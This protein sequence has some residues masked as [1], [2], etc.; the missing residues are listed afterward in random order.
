[1]ISMHPILYYGKP[2]HTWQT[3][4]PKG[5]FQ[6]GRLTRGLS[7]DNGHPCPKPI[8]DWNWLMQKISMAGETVIDPFLGSGT[9][10]LTAK[11]LD[12]RGIGIEIEEK[13]CE[14]AAKRLSQEVLCFSGTETMDNL[15]GK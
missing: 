14:I 2:P 6:T 8:A 15:S 5:T 3:G 11:Q 7:P 13:Y 1:M 12:R 9:T 10:L 4:W